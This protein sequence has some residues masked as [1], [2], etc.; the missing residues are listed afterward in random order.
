[1]VESYDS[2][3]EF[4]DKFSRQ[5][6]QTIIRG[7]AGASG[8]TLEADDYLPRQPDLPVLG[9]AARTLLLEAVADPNGIVMRIHHLGGLNV[10]ANGKQFC[11]TGNARDE[12]RWEAT[13][14]ELEN[15]GLIHDR[16]YKGE[17][18]NVTDE[19]YRVAD[20]LRVDGQTAI[21]VTPP[22]NSV[23]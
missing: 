17:I 19:G 10:Q 5:L 3:G 18:Y 4:R 14:E 15:T 20:L 16:G 13:I 23:H 1:M 22:Q 7:F 6:S 21:T 12:A 11:Q 2:V 9:E 8:S